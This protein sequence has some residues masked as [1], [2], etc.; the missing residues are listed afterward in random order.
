MIA[1]IRLYHAPADSLMPDCATSLR[2]EKQRLNL[3]EVDFGTDAINTPWTFDS[4]DSEH[5]SL[6]EIGIGKAMKRKRGYGTSSQSKANLLS[7]LRRNV[8]HD[9]IGRSSRSF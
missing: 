5:H 2:H 1:S 7:R 4:D 3:N 9:N 8:T 6:V